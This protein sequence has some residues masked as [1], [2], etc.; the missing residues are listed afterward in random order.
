MLVF[1]LGLMFCVLCCVFGLCV[2]LVSWC[3]CWWVDGG[4]LVVV[5]VCLGLGLNV[6]GLGFVWFC[7]CCFV[8]GLVFYVVDLVI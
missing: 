4:L 2:L 5:W 7:G 1:G 6:C 3:T 8:W